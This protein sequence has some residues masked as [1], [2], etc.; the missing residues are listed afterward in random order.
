[1]DGGDET[2]MGLVSWRGRESRWPFF[3]IYIPTSPRPYTCW[4][5]TRI[6][7]P[8]VLGVQPITPVMWLTWSVLVFFFKFFLWN[9]KLIRL[10]GS[11]GIHG[12]PVM[13][14]HQSTRRLTNYNRTSL[15]F[16]QKKNNHTICQKLM[17][18]RKGRNQPNRVQFFGAIWF[19]FEFF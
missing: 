5:V 9:L 15:K 6:T 18:P 12:R 13:E 11:F 7:R 1:M 14:H 19:Q 10:K 17:N 16:S 3:Y 2:E 8:Y 4:D